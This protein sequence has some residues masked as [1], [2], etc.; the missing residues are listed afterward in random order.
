MGRGGGTLNARGQAIVGVKE[1]H[2]EKV[3]K[4]FLYKDYQEVF[5]PPG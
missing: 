5:I 2:L 4:G 1:G 3:T